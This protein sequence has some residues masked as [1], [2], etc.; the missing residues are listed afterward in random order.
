[1]LKHMHHLCLKFSSMNWL[2]LPCFFLRIRL[3]YDLVV[4]SDWSEMIQNLSDENV[5]N[6]A[7][8]E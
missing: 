2:V 8:K 6:T 5:L 3:K 7:L 4:Q 1:M